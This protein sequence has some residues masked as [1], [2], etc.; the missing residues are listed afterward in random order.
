MKS[1]QIFQATDDPNY[2]VILTEWNNMEDGRNF[3]QSE[4]LKEANRE[5]GVIE[6]FDTHDTSKSLE[7]VEKKSV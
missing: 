5:S 6:M 3:L 2:L 7:E 4:E 1:Y